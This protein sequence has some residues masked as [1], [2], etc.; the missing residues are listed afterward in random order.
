M[1]ILGRRVHTHSGRTLVWSCLGLL[2]L[3]PFSLGVLYITAIAFAT[4]SSA[5]IGTRIEQTI[6]LSSAMFGLFALWWLGITNVYLVFR[7]RA[8][9][10][11]RFVWVGI[12]V[13]VLY[14]IGKPIYA[15]AIGYGDF[16]SWI[17]ILYHALLMTI[18]A[19]FTVIHIRLQRAIAVQ[20]DREQLLA[21]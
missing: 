21:D 15:I 4:W 6:S 14:A 10:I 20:L 9:R 8:L 17:A 16:L 3:V 11:P 13:G 18:A 2:V 1:F 12:V 7:S 5:P 19:G